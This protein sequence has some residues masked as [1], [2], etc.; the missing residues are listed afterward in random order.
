[1]DEQS[2]SGF[3]LPSFKYN[4]AHEGKLLKM[5]IQCPD[6]NGEMPLNNARCFSAVLMA[7]TEDSN[8]DLIAI[9]Q[10]IEIQYGPETVNMFKMLAKVINELDRLSLRSPTPIDDTI[11]PI[12]SQDEAIS[13]GISLEKLK[14]DREQAINRLIKKMDCSHCPYNPE[15]VHKALKYSLI[16]D[17]NQFYRLYAQIIQSVISN[18]QPPECTHCINLTGSDLLYLQEVLDNLRQ[19]ILSKAFRIVDGVQK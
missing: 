17:I 12:P 16:Q 10:Y 15:A 2:T 13:S 18:K 1:M 3:K 14:F 9:S 19:Y 8:I 5:I 7:M 6:C 4:I 11:P